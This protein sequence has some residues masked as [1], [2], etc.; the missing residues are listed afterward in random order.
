[1][2]VDS[3]QSDKQSITATRQYVRVEASSLPFF[4]YGFFP[5]AGLVALLLFGWTALA[6][7]AVQGTA[8][9]VANR[10]LTEAGET[11]ARAKASGQWITLEGTPPS[12]EAGQ[13]AVDAV[14]GGA[15]STWLGKARPVTRIKTK[16][17]A[18]ASPAQAN[19]ITAAAPAHEF[20]FRLS[21]G[22][23]TLSGRVPSEALKSELGARAEALRHPP[24]LSTVVNGL[25]ATGSAPVDGFAPIAERAIDNIAKCETGTASFADQT[26]SFRCQA[27]DG[28]V[29]GIRSAVRAGLPLGAF[30]RVEILP[31][32]AVA[33]CEDELARLLAAARIEFAPG[34]T[35]LNVNSGAVLDLAARAASD[36]PGT[37]R[38]EGHTDT[39]GNALLNDD[40]SLRRAEAVRAAMIE[41]GVPAER[42]LAAG[43]GQSRPVGDN[44]TEEGRARNRRIEIRI[45]RPDE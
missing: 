3:T 21:A 27:D 7:S 29:P 39:T 12:P 18:P 45:V 1:M 4:P 40:L 26:F 6:F 38:V 43:F 44:A 35:V 9:S 5:I 11:W 28:A 23:L 42:L 41:R 22:T 33:N 14:R 34:S 17:T 25:E 8:Q 31:L 36:C 16:Y 15:T 19:S 13:R 30:G 32:E 10:Q 20:L 24:I 2:S 37:L